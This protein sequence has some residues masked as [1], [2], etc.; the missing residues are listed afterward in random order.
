MQPPIKL[1]NIIWQQLSKHHWDVGILYCRGGNSW[2][3]EG[4]IGIKKVMLGSKSSGSAG[5]IMEN[6]RPAICPNISHHLFLPLSWNQNARQ[7]EC[8]KLVPSIVCETCPFLHWQGQAINDEIS[9][10][11]WTCYHYKTMES[12]MVCRQIFFGTTA[13][14]TT[15]TWDKKSILATTLH[16]QKVSRSLGS[17]PVVCTR[18]QAIFRRRLTSVRE[19]SVEPNW[20]WHPTG[21]AWTHLH[22]TVCSCCD[23]TQI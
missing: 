23:T 9:L 10:I 11:N 3:R 17:N 4:S 7:D 15:T 8:L 18:T 21:D 22:W 2:T 14:N 19:L 12:L 16:C 6:H 5:L 13:K 20:S 1:N